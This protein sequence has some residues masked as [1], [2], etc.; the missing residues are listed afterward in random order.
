MTQATYEPP[1]DTERRHLADAALASRVTLAQKRLLTADRITPGSQNVA[2][3]Y[4][5]HGELDEQRLEGAL[6]ETIAAHPQVCNQ[7]EEREGAWE[8][9]P[10]T[11]SASLT[12]LDLSSKPDSA[13][14]CWARA[15][16][17]AVEPFEPGRGALFRVVLLRAEGGQQWLVMVAHHA[18]I[19]GA[20][21]Q[22]FLQHWAAA[23]HTPGVSE[24]RSRPDYTDYIAWEQEVLD[25][26]DGQGRERFWSEQAAGFEFQAP[27][28]NVASDATGRA[29][30]LLKTSLPGLLARAAEYR[31]PPFAVV[32]AVF[33]VVLHRFSR[34]SDLAVAVVSSTRTSE[35]WRE[36]IL[37]LINLVPVRS[38]FQSDGEF[39]AFA[40]ETAF[41]VLRALRHQ[42]WHSLEHF[43][44]APG[45]RHWAGCHAVISYL[46][47]RSAPPCF[48]DVILEA[49]DLEMPL[50]YH[51]LVL[52]VEEQPAGAIA[53]L[54]FDASLVDPEIA[55]ALLD[56]LATAI[57]N[58]P[59]RTLLGELP[60]ISGEQR[61]ALLTEFNPPPRAFP[62][63]S[64][65]SQFAAAVRLHPDRIA[66]E[67]NGTQLSY[68]ALH[69]LSDS[70]AAELARRH[71]GVR[72]VVGL[73]CRRSPAMVAAL[74]GILKAGAA[75]LPIDPAM[76]VERR[77]FLLDDAEVSGV[78]VDQAVEGWVPGR[79]PVLTLDAVP[80]ESELHVR[81]EP[82]AA[83]DPAYRLYTSG[84][85]G[86]PKAVTVL[87]GNLSAFLAAM[88]DVLHQPDAAPLVTQGV[89]LAVTRL[90]F[91]IA[92]V[93]LLWTLTRGYRVVLST[94]LDLGNGSTLPSL[95]TRS[96]LEP[97]ITH[98]QCTPSLLG[99][100][101]EDATFR[102][103]IGGLRYL[104]LGGEVLRPQVLERV[105]ALSSG[106]RVV[107]VYGPTETT[108][109][110]T[111]CDVTHDLSVSV[112]IG[113]PMTNVRVYLLDLADQV[114]PRGVPGELC[115]AGPLVTPGY[116]RR[117][118]LNAQKFTMD[119]F[120]ASGSERMYRTGDRA[121]WRRDGNLQ[122]LG[123]KDEQIKLRGYRIELGEIEAVAARHPAILQVAVVMTLEASPRLVA[124]YS[125]ASTDVDQE[126]LR[127]S[128]VRDLPPYM[129]PELWL[130]VEQLPLTR[131][132]KI[133]RKAL[134]RLPLPEVTDNEQLTTTEAEIATL[135][136]EVLAGT[137]KVGR[138][139]SFFEVGGDSL[140]A[141]RLTARL[142][143]S[144]GVDLAVRDLF[145][146][147]TLTSMARLVESRHRRLGI[148][149]SPLLPRGTAPMLSVAQE[150]LW[151]VAQLNLNPALYNENVVVRLR[152]AVDEDR[153]RRALAAVVQRHA[154][155]R[156]VYDAIDG[157]PQARVLDV[158]DLE[159]R[160]EPWGPPADQPTEEGEQLAEFASR[161][162]H[163]DRELPI[164]AAI[165]RLAEAENLLQIVV[166]HIAWDG[167]SADVLAREVEALYAAYENGREAD[168][169]EPLGYQFF[170]YV[171]WQRAQAEQE[172]Y[173]SS[174][175]YWQSA[176]QGGDGIE[177]PTDRLPVGA[178]RF[179][180]GNVRFGL[181]LGLTHAL[182]ARAR[183]EG[184][185]PFMLLLAAFDAL[186]LRYTGGEQ[187]RVGTPVAVRSRA[188]FE[189]NIG[190]FV[191]TVVVPAQAS[192]DTSFRQLLFG[193]RDSVLL[194]FEHA[195]VPFAH[196]VDAVNPERTEHGFSLFR[197]MFVMQNAPLRR[198][199][200]P[201]VEVS[202]VRMHPSAAR[203][204]LTLMVEPEPDGF[205][206]LL[207]YDAE[208]LE[209]ETV[210]ALR[211]AFTEILVQVCDDPSRSIEDLSF[212]TQ[213]DANSALHTPLPAR[214][215][216]PTVP[217]RFGQ[218]TSEH[219]RAVAVRD[220]ER[221]CSYAELEASSQRVALHIGG[222]AAPGTPLAILSSP[223]IGAVA[224]GLGAWKANCCVTYLETNT[225][226]ARLTAALS[227][228]DHPLVLVSR[229]VLQGRP[230]L[231]SVLRELA[232]VLVLEDL[233]E[234]EPPFAP[235]LPPPRP[236]DSLYVV[237]TSGTTGLPKGIEQSHQS[238]S[239][240][241]DW[242]A[243]C[244]GVGPRRN[245]AVWSPLSYDAGL[246][247]LLGALCFGATAC[248]CGEETRLAPASCAR[249]LIDEEID[250]FQSVPSFAR[251]LL[252][253][254]LKAELELGPHR[255]S[256][257]LLSGELLDPTF[258]RA[259]LDA[260]RGRTRLYNLY[261]PSEMVLASWYRV[262][263]VPEQVLRIPVGTAIDGR[264]I[265]VCDSKGRVVPHGMVGEVYVRS[266]YLTKG[267]YRQP[268][269][270]A[271]SFLENPHSE[272]PEDRLYRTGDWA[273]FR[274]D[275]QLE[276]RGR[277]DGLVKVLGN[278]VEL[279]DIESAILRSGVVNE[280]CVVA[281]KID[282]TD[283]LVAYLVEP[284]LDLT[285]L[286]R[287][288]AGELPR[289]MLPSHYVLLERLPRT[290][291]SKVD[292]AALPP[293]AAP[294]RSAD[295]SVMTALERSI[296]DVF[297]EC[298]GNPTI[299]PEDNFFESGGHS[300]LLARAHARLEDALARKIPLLS[301][302]RYGSARAV[303]EQLE[304]VAPESP[305]LSQRRGAV[306]A[307]RLKNRRVPARK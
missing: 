4:R 135:W 188:E 46:R 28:W 34:T 264:E 74:L 296:V 86:H 92:V 12:I 81:A 221:S 298:L 214:V 217:E 115:I 169:L 25:G 197:A 10:Q 203:C 73:C 68:A 113:R 236:S 241:L 151:F 201:G 107:N 24:R 174:L 102:T 246:C 78:V 279:G 275:G 289:Y 229:A 114:V 253:A 133:D 300:L 261:G 231:D 250:V 284:N 96:A 117:P 249:W 198:L 82:C 62:S 56:S 232:S 93:E 304:S 118:E 44:S 94:E 257:L 182:E 122:F 108:V 287:K 252:P 234:Q 206:C 116:F 57:D 137:P 223:T 228:F 260:Y 244:F 305:E 42:P 195:Q 293:P 181:D 36:L 69:A 103:V 119:P 167:W 9:R 177:L 106:A 120:V 125:S 185:T 218:V 266:P 219:P 282:G 40:R 269:E 297:R 5:V 268:E 189:D 237:Y 31:L 121:R 17:L 280:C 79:L 38:S 299:G 91:D 32:L 267:Y 26:P 192:A 37:P 75:Y 176:L 95:A 50:Q 83:S 99:V 128:V 255:L 67:C 19:D 15:R 147:A 159:V 142:R 292:R 49:C 21:L 163:L 208:L 3:F 87:H 278:R 248:L 141:L 211:K 196:V 130:R 39:L 6:A 152:G 199:T 71:I 238:F 225:P 173:R 47:E 16:Q 157:R 136:N 272:D 153:L 256:T 294:T 29:P 1:H 51:P 138:A 139:T 273:R 175:R 124:Y 30:T 166:H 77:R 247:E 171:S 129:V 168:A 126:Q 301:L 140:L 164:R 186:L 35:R 105:R 204:E 149:P 262:E 265:L 194:G 59:R 307:W 295:E 258:A 243:R 98:L 23:Y 66:L 20:S 200:L 245:V 216:W 100:L 143:D 193:I 97:R 226:Q 172:S 112:P 291:T 33:Q 242:Q 178:R 84:S 263:D 207:T 271:R 55:Q 212:S 230:E 104:L 127:S 180:A 22:I 72:Q 239:Q 65:V 45:D 281:R 213:Y 227:Q 7:F 154:V 60:L 215:S 111:A 64:V 170:D 148:E 288:L 259:W 150:Q 187:I 27:D 251:V 13:R 146:A 52:E 101:L 11:A 274:A 286:R 290:R 88:D 90:T 110:A 145:G 220:G 54:S 48:A 276:F 58:A 235:L 283:Q 202:R 179:P 183:V 156:T 89:F 70:I 158:A 161:P 270:T 131:S 222:V 61:T 109:W 53:R 41:K 184:V 14:E 240:F 302:L 123:R 162:F 43:Q 209:P 277:R 190:C 63:E 306:R 134:Q 132:G 144:L 8:R 85:T 205:E 210:E 285:V 191:N 233:L 18:I 160:S 76:P 303:A 165:Y 80:T 155:L 2:A 224:A 254:L